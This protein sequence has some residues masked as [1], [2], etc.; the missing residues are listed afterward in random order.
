M[1]A[2]TTALA[3]QLINAV[4]RSTSYVSPGAVYLAAFST[5]PA[6]NG[7]GTEVTGGSYARVS[8][9]FSA[10]VNGTTS[11]TNEADILG[12]PAVTVNGL[13]LFDASSGGNMLFFGSLATP[14]TANA[15]DTFIVKVGDLNIALG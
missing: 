6:A 5:T 10:P 11:N 13:A 2:L 7:S 15:G 14:K 9:S 8:M 12:M 1:A 3:N 4:L